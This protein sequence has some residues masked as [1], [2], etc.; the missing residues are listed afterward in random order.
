MADA[1]RVQ[2]ADPQAEQRLLE[3]LKSRGSSRGEL[4][5]LTRSD[6][7]AL[8][9]MPSEQAEPALKALVKAYRSHLAVT[10][11]GELVYQFDPSFERRDRVSLGERLRQGGALLWKGFAFLFKIWIMVTLVAYVIAF[12]AMA[13]VLI[14]A[15]SQGDRNNSR[16]SNSDGGMF[17][18]WYW[19]MP[20]MAPRNRYGRQLQRPNTPKKRFYVAIFD[21]VF[22]PSDKPHD[23]READRRL[24]AFL[25]DKKGRLVTSE[26]VA[27]T[28]LSYQA[29]D[30]ELTRLSVEYNGQV[31]VSDDGSL[32]YRF[33]ELLPSA[34]AVAT[35][36]NYAWDRHPPVPML[37]GNSSGA[38][39]AITAF[40][41][42]NLV[43]SMTIGP[44][45]L[46]AKGLVHTPGLLFL[47]TTFPLIF[48]LIFFAVP[49]LRWFKLRQQKKRMKA[50]E[51]RNRLLREIWL[52]SDA[53]LDP[54][55]L[56]TAVA[57]AHQESVPRVT[58]LLDQLLVELN[59]EIENT[60]GGAIRY[61]FAKLRDERR[62]VEAERQQASTPS[63]GKVVFSSEI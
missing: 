39:V 11:S 15:Q 50:A 57:A 14:T 24:I 22:G 52:H 27:L 29:A 47:V 51:L 13:I 38:N 10:E 33:D 55:A 35:S 25:R 60:E 18:L 36:W 43:A 61:R 56:V 8:T 12:L 32:V 59:G 44:A 54:A 21:Y 34:D 45:F 37:T 7:V 19:L 3:A 46:A 53:P 28:G 41:A 1:P 17:W 63:L 31:E 30:E 42:F 2:V 58:R 5:R 4:L 20:D 49:T 6:A 16:R 62:V 9:G 23:P 26:L 48:S 40:T